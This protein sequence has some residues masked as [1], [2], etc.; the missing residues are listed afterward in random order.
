MMVLLLP[1]FRSR[2]LKMAS[3][4]WAPDLLKGNVPSV[5]SGGLSISRAAWSVERKH[6]ECQLRKN[7]FIEQMKRWELQ[8]S[9]GQI[10][11]LE[12]IQMISMTL[13]QLYHTAWLIN[14]TIIM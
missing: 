12:M 6:R 10:Q 1:M 7:V 13:N 8:V 5:S 9:Q 3:S 14:C 11:D 4:S 2:S